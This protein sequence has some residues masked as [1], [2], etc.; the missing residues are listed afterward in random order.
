MFLNTDFE[1]WSIM[2]LHNHVTNEPA[3]STYVALPTASALRERI[4][5]LTEL[6]DEYSSWINVHKGKVVPVLN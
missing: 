1:G 6:T 4:R 2:S 3:A 5:I